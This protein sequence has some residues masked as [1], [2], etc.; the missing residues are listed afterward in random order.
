[1]TIHVAAIL[2]LTNACDVP[3]VVPSHP[4]KAQPST[5]TSHTFVVHRLWELKYPIR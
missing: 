2:H 3:S 4:Q 5:G 1:M